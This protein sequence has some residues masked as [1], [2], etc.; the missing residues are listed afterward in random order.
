MSPPLLL[1]LYL[2]V[3][4]LPLGLA[5]AG[6]RPPRP[7]LDELASG[8][9]MLAFAVILVEFVLSG[10]F[11]TVSA[12]LGMDR[13]MR[14]HQL[15]ARSALAFALVHPFLYTLPYDRPLPFDPTR[16]LTLTVDIAALGSGMAAFVL[17][18]AFVVFSI[19]RSDLPWRYEAWRLMHGLGALAIAGL[20]LHH[21]LSAGRYAEDPAL[22]WT[23]VAL[24][25]IAVATLL[26]VYLFKPLAQL[27]RPWRVTRVEPVAERTWELALAPEGHDGLAYR[28]GEFAW[29]N[30]GHTPFSLAENPF[31][32]SSAPSAGAELRF[33]IKEFGDFSR[34]VGRI[35]PGTRA[36]LDGPH[37]NLVV[38]GRREPGIAL[39][40]GGVGIAP[41]LG[42]L[43]ELRLRQD[44]RPLALVYGNRKESQI[45][46]RAELDAAA[47]RPGVE[48]VHVLSEPPEGWRGETGMVSEDL[49]RRLFGSEARRRWLYVLCGPAPML[50]AV[51]RALIDLGVPARR[52]LSERFEYD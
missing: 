28:A 20:L 4:L 47:E 49:L 5:V 11:R 21:A 8:L 13:T 52:I 39:I 26:V 18:P 3:T 38:D 50:V 51:E 16:Q 32:I 42:I 34:S 1:A 46:H 29:V 17:L 7:V 14:L 35:A 25:A 41:L 15:L 24:S 19:Y 12:R 2:G 27:R 6:G 9:G 43:R 36:H 48:V 37:G 44:P 45:V 22:A 40:A 33:V 30:V 23:W 31:S 10:R